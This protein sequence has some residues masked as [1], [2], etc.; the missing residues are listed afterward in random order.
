VEIERSSR[1]AAEREI[2]ILRQRL[3]ELGE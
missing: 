1:E 3:Q 2:A